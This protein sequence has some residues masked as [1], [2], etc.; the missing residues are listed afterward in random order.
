MTTVPTQALFLMNGAVVAEHSQHAAQRMTGLGGD[1]SRPCRSRIPA[2]PGSST[3]GRQARRRPDVPARFSGEADKALAA[4]CQT[5][6]ASAEFR[7]L[8]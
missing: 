4:L 7:Y 5:L 2:R 3:N 8:Y 1:E 6:F